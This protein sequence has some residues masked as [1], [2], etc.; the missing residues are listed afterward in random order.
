MGGGGGG[1]FGLNCECVACLPERPAK[2]GRRP[3]PRPAAQIL[4]TAP[5]EAEPLF[6]LERLAHIRCLALTLA[7]PS[8]DRRITRATVEIHNSVLT[9]RCD[10]ATDAGPALALALR[11]D[12]GEALAPA[13]GE[14]QL[15]DGYAY[16]RLPLAPA[17]DDPEEL[18]VAASEEMRL[19]EEAGVY[20]RAAEQRRRERAA[21]QGAWLRCAACDA[22]VVQLPDRL[23]SA[24]H[25][26]A[27]QLV[28]FVQCCQELSF[29]WRC[30]F[31]AVEADDDD[32]AQ[33]ALRLAA[34]PVGGGFEG[35]DDPAAGHFPPPPPP[36][37]SCLL[38]DH[39]V[40]LAAAPPPALT[41]VADE[42]FELPACAARE[43]A[44]APTSW[45]PLR[46][47][48]GHLVGFAPVAGTPP[49]AK[50]A[51]P[52]LC[53]DEACAAGGH[54]QLL[55]AALA[56]A[57]M[58]L[59]PGAD[60]ELFG[61]HTLSTRLASR[62]LRVAADRGGEAPH[63]ALVADGAPPL[64]VTLLSPHATVRTNSSCRASARQ[65]CA[66]ASDA[67]KVLFAEARDGEAAAAEL[68][69]WR[70]ERAVEEV[71][72]WGGERDKVRDQLEASALMLPPSSRAFAAFRVGFIPA[73]P[74]WD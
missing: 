27:D 26:D 42:A 1:L 69:R 15:A 39:A 35:D 36:P 62:L 59:G 22:A 24:P 67:L 37:A 9:A 70:A 8:A 60:R 46:C 7:P 54:V 73:A 13:G 31:P 52:P 57:E 12:V 19:R 72:L 38:A 49:T 63:F 14:M 17:A 29:D 6:L 10:V 32:P 56:V 2:R 65:W 3:W 28:D 23:A 16:A 55:K 58:P 41:A 11:V 48:C 47:D 50:R 61:G 51:P 30:V 43:R 18:R 4:A 53:F 45:A 21:L 74:T 33:A 66:E 20:R 64:L 40:L 68:A 71:P 5:G 44:G 25:P 34:R